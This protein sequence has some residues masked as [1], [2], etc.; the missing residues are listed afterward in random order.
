MAIG[1]V[2]DLEIIFKKIHTEIDKLIIEKT[3]YLQNKLNSIQEYLLKFDDLKFEQKLNYLEKINEV[4]EYKIKSIEKKENTIKEKIK[5]VNNKLAKAYLSNKEVLQKFLNHKDE[6]KKT[7]HNICIFHNLFIKIKEKINELEKCTEKMKVI[8][9]EFNSGNLKHNEID[10]LKTFA[11]Y[12]LN[13]YKD[14][15]CKLDDINLF[16]LSN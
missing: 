13:I 4:I 3:L 14:I 5:I 11:N 10:N 9:H 1:N 12:F 15:S 8:K 16:Q 7:K 2:E 6:I